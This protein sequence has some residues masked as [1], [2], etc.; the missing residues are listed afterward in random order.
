VCGRAGGLLLRRRPCSRAGI[1]ARPG[2]LVESARPHHGAIA[3]GGGGGGGVGL[4]LGGASSLFSAEGGSE[5]SRSD[6]RSPAAGR[7]GTALALRG[8]RPR[9]RC[10][11]RRLDAA[12]AMA[13]TAGAG[14]HAALLFCAA[15]SACSASTQVAVAG[16]AGVLLVCCCC[17][18]AAAAAA[19]AVVC[20]RRGRVRVRVRAVQCSA[21]TTAARIPAMPA[22]RPKLARLSA[23]LYFH[24]PCYSVLLAP[25]PS[26]SRRHILGRPLHQ[27]PDRTSRRMR[28]PPPLRR[29]ARC[30]FDMRTPSAPACQ[31]QRPE[32]CQRRR[33]APAHGTPKATSPCPLMPS[34]PRGRANP[35]L[36]PS[37]AVHGHALGTLLPFALDHLATPCATVHRHLHTASLETGERHVRPRHGPPRS[38]APGAHARQLCH[39]QPL[40]RPVFPS[41][42]ELAWLPSW[43]PS[44]V[45]QGPALPASGASRVGAEKNKKLGHSINTRGMHM[46]CDHPL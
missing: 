43:R 32:T 27:T 6:Q 46:L 22:K 11:G 16:A 12:A 40:R 45:A 42:S 28:V 15:C 13:A 9:G 33:R 7:C 17:C 5:Q 35:V 18:A 1:V 20:G 19:A 26:D 10:G 39:P 30:F 44:H 14:V 25:R 8:V 24:P 29:R 21:R 38:L 37:A 36:H 31:R 4:R 34:C 23:C 3:R 2:R 41:T